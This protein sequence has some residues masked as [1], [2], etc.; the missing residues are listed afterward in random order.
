MDITDSE[1]AQPAEQDGE[2]PIRFR[3]VL[4]SHASHD[5]PAGPRGRPRAAARA[6]DA[7]DP[8]GAASADA[9]ADTG[10]QR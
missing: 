10:E 7:A 1:R 8:D 2:P 9:V 5:I 6:V 3:Y 4:W